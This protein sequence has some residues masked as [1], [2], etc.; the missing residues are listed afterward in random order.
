MS[1]KRYPHTFWLYTITKYQ[2]LHTSN[3]SI[4]INNV[5]SSKKDDKKCEYEGWKA[6][7]FKRVYS[8]NR[9]FRV[10]DWFSYIPTIS[11]D[12]DYF[13]QHWVPNGFFMQKW[14]DSL[15]SE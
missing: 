10:D 13:C 2:C 1:E 3:V 11:K 12:I 15:V 4:A 9:D 6:Q 7:K 14:I 5:K 8:F